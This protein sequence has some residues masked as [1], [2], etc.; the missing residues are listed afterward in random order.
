MPPTT[1]AFAAQL[2]TIAAKST[3][4]LDLRARRDAHAE[5]LIFDRP[6]AAKQDWDTIYQICVEGFH[7]LCVLDSR[8]REFDQNLFSPQ[9]KEQDREQLNKTQNEALG[10][11]I[12]RC[13]AILGSKILLRPGVR[14]VEWLVRRFRVHV[15]NTS[16]LLATF[17]S[18]HETPV[19]R[20]LLSI[21]PANKIVNEW[22]FLGPYHNTAANLPRHTI[23]YSAT[24]NDAF[25]SYFN[26]Y[27]LRTC[28]EGAG[29]PQLLRFW[30]TL[31]VEAVTGRLNQVRSGRKEVEK[32]RLEDALIK[33]VPVLEEGFEIKDSPE[34]TVTCFT[35]SLLLASNSN[36]QDAVIDSLMRS[37][38]SHIQPDN[39]DSKAALACLIV[40]VT[41]KHEPKVPKKVLELLIKQR[42][43]KLRLL[44]LKEQV[45]IPSCLEVL[46]NSSLTGLKQSN[47]DSRL[48]FVERLFEV[49]LG[50]VDIQ[51]ISRCLAVILR[52]LEGAAG[53]PSRE[54]LTSLLRRLNDNPNFSPAFPEAIQLAGKSLGDIEEVLETA[55]ES[56][57]D[58][59]MI[60]SNQ[61][62]LTDPAPE[63]SFESEKLDS[64]LARLPAES[65]DL[66]FLAMKTSPLFDQLLQAFALCHKSEDA[67]ARFEALPLWGNSVDQP[68][69]LKTSFYLRVAL[70][71]SVAPHQVVALRSLSHGLERASHAP[72]QLLFPYLTI[73]LAD[74]GQPVRRGA[75]AC[76]LGLRKS[77]AKDTT[78]AT[79]ETTEVYDGLSMKNMKRLPTGQALKLLDQVVI[80]NLE[81]CILEALHIHRVLE[82]AFNSL[83]RSSSSGTKTANVELK[84]SLKHD[85]FDQ[86][87]LCATTTPLT[88]VKLRVIELLGGV[89]KVGSTST[90]RALAPVLKTWA[91]LKD[92]EAEAVATAEDLSLAHIDAV[93]VQIINGR[94][95]EAVEQALEMLKEASSHMRVALVTAFF[96][97]LTLIWKDVRRESQISSAGLLFDMSFSDNHALASGSR[98]VLQSVT[99][100]TEIL[101]SFFE[102]A[103]SGMSDLQTLAPPKKKRRTS[104]GRESLPRELAQTLTLVDSRLTFA[105]E[106]VENSKPEN[107]PQLLGDLFEVLIS[108]RRTEDRGVPASPYLTTLCLSSILSIVNEIRQARKPDLDVSKIRPD[109]VIDC[110]RSSE[111]PQVQSTALLLAASLASLAPDR[112]L[113][114]IMPIFTFMG[115]GILA[116]EDERSIYVTNQAIDQII[117]PLVA[118]LKKQDATN[119]VLSTSSLLSSFVTAFD[120]IPQHRRNAFYQRLLNRLGAEDFAFALIAL[121]VSR[122]R[123]Q[124]MSIFLSNL[125]G[126]LPPSTQLSTQKKI[127]DLVDDVFSDNPHN[128]DPLLNITKT[129]KNDQREEIAE[130]LLTT[131]SKLLGSSGLMF[132]VKRLHKL[133]ESEAE[134]FWKVYR[135]A[136]T[137]ILSILKDQK[138]NHPSL[139][140]TTRDCLSALLGLPSLAELLHIMP[141]ILSEMEHAGDKELQPLALRVLATQLQHHAPKDSHTQSEAMALL[142]TI[143][144]I[145]GSSEEEALRHAAITL[146]DRIVEIYGRKSPDAIIAASNV[147]IEGAHGLNSQDPR[148]QVM[149]LLC[150]ASAVEA[151]KEAAVPI[152]LTSMSKVLGLLEAS[153]AGDVGNTELHNAAFTLLSSFIS[154]VSFMVSDENAVEIL[155]LCHKSSAAA[156]ELDPSCKESRV[157]ALELLAKKIDLSTVIDSLNKVWSGVV[158]DITLETVTE[159]FDLLSRAIDRNS[160][161][162]VVR[163]AEPITTFLLQVLDLRRLVASSSSEVALS[164]EDIKLVESRL[165][166]LSIP[167]IYKL[168]DTAFR[169]LFET[170]VD[171]AIKPNDVP[172]NANVKTARQTSLFGFVNHF[173]ATLK[174]IVTSYASYVLEPANAVLS[175]ATSGSTSMSSDDMSLYRSTLTL[176]TTLMEHDADGFFASPGH[177]SPLSDLL[178]S[179]LTLAS[180]KS[181]PLRAAVGELVIPAIVKLATATMDTPAH[182][183]AVNHGLCQLRH[184]SSAAVRLSAIRTHL[185][186]T[187]DENVGEE[188]VNNVVVG[189]STEG[190]GGSGE[191]MVYVNESLEDD[192]EEVEREVRRWVNMVREMVGE[193]VFEV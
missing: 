40:L 75:A 86:L 145:I 85:L 38:A 101:A 13:L 18:Y 104:H 17:L 173:F 169:P 140:S 149:S 58:V 6:V 96:D 47:F 68:S 41:R 27:V 105:L 98:N 3:N 114:T 59:Q 87:I 180:A 72:S 5:S 192:D 167:F 151:L 34:V 48:A 188:W 46:V 63:N 103:S 23:V 44:E 67:L 175:A 10:V 62:E 129:T 16:V 115:H 30:G 143:Q 66:S 172:A 174:S 45:P 36:L 22:K 21:I 89:Q 11:V 80:P 56:M 19:F 131:A 106:I 91:T 125:V 92:D 93:M 52:K 121:L 150:L 118:T 64:M 178:V 170:W 155:S 123:Q 60:E 9:A 165:Q 53:T 4:E 26:N 179:Q 152:V 160:K 69:D 95:K 7:E 189:A 65:V 134:S 77:L 113:H 71:A 183:H 153:L 158:A 51:T 88:K 74:P 97:R 116:K 14:A 50:L 79:S 141:E 137:Q 39:P 12:E 133:G 110:A 120:H 119:L 190:V 146:L 61:M 124:D 109:L 157:E 159:Y 25:F 168:N 57:D 29:H 108:L 161:P 20:N 127:L 24:H 186:L 177:F 142:P 55:I 132:S 107:H 100:S 126:D 37:V 166:D 187:Q 136:L 181:K 31:V 76:L 90:S 162:A 117:P 193:D 28:Q 111:N 182:H 139:T 99:L 148:T 130:V 82:T 94:S 171:W 184:K 144:T 43:L 49:T 81:E 33:I 122:R 78:E 164:L 138:V 147:L 156:P 32:Q 8:L 191:T 70:K 2:R 73:L 42:D 83:S 154:H 163:N 35:I 185:A 102:L 112:I 135:G 54:Y 84:K 128:A 15:Y 1:S 176:L